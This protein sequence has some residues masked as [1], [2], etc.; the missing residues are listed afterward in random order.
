M[1]TVVDE[2]RRAPHIVEDHRGLAQVLLGVAGLPQRGRLP[3]IF[4]VICVVGGQAKALLVAA[5]AR[6]FIL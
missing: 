4:V 1:A 5:A 6:I 3:A 2:R